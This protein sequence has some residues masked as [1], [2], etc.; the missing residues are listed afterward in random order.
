[1]K[2]GARFLAVASGPLYERKKSTTL[3]VGV[4]GRKGVIEGILSGRVDIDGTDATSKIIKMVHKSRF[5]EQI[6]AI[7]I[8]G[9]AIAGLNVVDVKE[10]ER[11]TGISVIVL[12]RKKPDFKALAKAL[13]SSE[14]GYG[15]PAKDKI[16]MIKELNLERPFRKSEG[17]YIQAGEIDYEGKASTAFELL[18]LAHMIANGVSTGISKGRI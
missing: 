8:N 5:E 4:I 10:I 7:A 2:E 3:L 9:I 13:K 15:D 12:T 6:K 16:A 1:M 14:K 11:R 18:R 17:F